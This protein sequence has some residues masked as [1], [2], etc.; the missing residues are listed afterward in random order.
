MLPSR[1]NIYRRLEGTTFVFNTFSGKIAAF[2]GLAGSLLE[3]GELAVMPPSQL[4]RAA[5]I[6]AVV[7]DELDEISAFRAAYQ[8]ALHSRE[9]L[10]IVAFLTYRCNLRCGYCFEVE[11][12][13][14]TARMDVQTLERLIGAVQRACTEARTS[15]LAVTLFGGEPLLEVAKG[16][17]LLE[18][19]GGWARRRGMRFFAAMSTNG[20]LL[21]EK[22][23]GPLAPH[24]D[25]VQVAFDGPQR[26]HDRVRMSA[27]GAP[28]YERIIK[29]IELV[30]RQ[31]CPITV[32]IRIQA[33]DPA[34]AAE[35]LRDLARRG[36]VGHERVSCHVAIRQ[37][38]AHWKC[39][40]AEETILDPASPAARELLSL[41][42]DLLAP[43]AP[44]VQL[45]PCITCGN[46][47]CV[48]PSGDLYTCLGSTTAPERKVGA[49]TEHGFAFTPAHARFQSRD[50]TTFAE[51]RDC[52]YL[53]LCGGGCPTA[54][55]REYGTIHHSWCGT[56][57]AVLESR[58][59]GAIAAA[60]AARRP[61]RP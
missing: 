28:T 16:A 26:V 40:Q 37:P 56:N 52:P 44:A 47:L 58:I 1:F 31:A 13:P 7:A 20:V 27:N 46:W 14:R 15:A 4:A 59:D 32:R 54:A 11:D 34:E 57:R 3:R 41:S 38:F 49:L 17:H 55:L 61:P 48:A 24:L 10:S 12:R 5:A 39:G 43:R 23:L 22:R 18:Q 30:L 42:S 19:L 33:G 6:G 8:N 60:R 2:G 35:L 51:C 53:P 36:L 45:L 21:D 25:E 50:P 9:I 29:G